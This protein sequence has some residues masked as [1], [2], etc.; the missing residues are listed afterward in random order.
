VTS[1]WISGLPAQSSS[2]VHLI[3]LAPSTHVFPRHHLGLPEHCISANGFRQDH[4]N[5]KCGQ[6]VEQTVETLRAPWVTST[7]WILNMMS[8]KYG[9]VMSRECGWA[10]WM[11]VGH[12]L[13]FQ[14]SQDR[15]PTTSK[16]SPRPC[17]GIPQV[18]E[19]N[20]SLFLLHIF[21]LLYSSVRMSEYSTASWRTPI[22]QRYQIHRCARSF[23]VHCRLPCLGVN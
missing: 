16:G 5:S 8:Q 13:L 14:I 11:P 4:K 6:T 19:F 12:G 10:L 7:K 22:S 17:P 23:A 3:S 9:H 2:K 1:V 15:Q 18:M 20:Q 21:I